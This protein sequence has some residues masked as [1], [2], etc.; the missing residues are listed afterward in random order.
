MGKSRC[1]SIMTTAVRAGS[2]VMDRA[3]FDGQLR[4]G[5]SP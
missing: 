3:R 5:V 1:M 2:I 4:H